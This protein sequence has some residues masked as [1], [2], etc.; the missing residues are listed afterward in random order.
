MKKGFEEAIKELESIITNLENR[1]LS[2]EESLKLFKEGVDLYQ[3]CN[4]QLDKAEKK[5][6]MIIDE[7]G[8]LKEV[9]FQKK[10][11]E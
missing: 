8:I 5:I 11:E 4:N 3:Y 7:N 6:S 10:E 1:E 9:P 2:L